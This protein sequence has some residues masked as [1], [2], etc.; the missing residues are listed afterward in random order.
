[1]RTVSSFVCPLFAS[2]G[3]WLLAAAS[4]QAQVLLTVTPASVAA[5][6]TGNVT[7]TV[8]GLTN[9]ESVQIAKYADLNKSGGIDSFEPVINAFRAQDGAATVIGGV[10]NINMPFDA[11]ATPETLVVKLNQGTQGFEQRMVGSYLITASSPTGRFA[12]QTVP[13]TITNSSAA[14]TLDGTVT[15]SGSPVPYAGVVIFPGN[16]ADSY[17]IFGVWAD[18]SGHYNV[19]LPAGTYTAM[20]LATSLV[21]DMQSLS[22]TT[23]SIGA[24]ATVNLTMATSTRVISGRLSDPNAPTVLFPAVSFALFSDDSHFV[25]ALADASGNF[26]VGV[27]PGTWH[28]SMDNL[29]VIS[30]LGYL[31]TDDSHTVDTTSGDVTGLVKEMAPATALIHGKITDANNNPIS[32]MEID[33]TDNDNHEAKVLTD[34]KG[35]FTLGVNAGVWNLDY[36]GDSPY[37][38][39]QTSGIFI[40]DGQ[41]VEANLTALPVSQTISGYLHTDSGTPLEGVGIW[42]NATLAGTTFNAYTETDENGFYSLGVAAGTWTVGVDSGSDSQSSLGSDYLIPASQ[43]VTLS[44]G[45]IIV[46]FTATKATC[47]IQGTVL[48]T[49][50]HAIA[51]VWVYAHATIGGVE[52]NCGAL[53][54][55][56]GGYQFGVIPGTWT[57]GLSC[58]SGDQTLNAMGYDCVMDESL[59]ILSGTA[60]INFSPS[61][62]D[63]LSVTTTSLPDGRVGNDYLQILSADGC[64]SPFTWSLAPSSAAL[65]E[66]LALTSSNFEYGWINGTPTVSGQFTVT[67]RVTDAN[68]ATA[69]QTFTFNIQPAA[70]TSPTISSPARLDASRIRFLV[71]GDAG[72]NYKVQYST[73]LSVDGWFTILTTNP[74]ATPFWFT[75]STTTRPQK[76]YRILIDN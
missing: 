2:V 1:M 25:F 15:C 66:G 10:T 11:N 45:D 75:D 40:R 4:L 50:N 6:Y 42:A 60:T 74:V 28:I 63:S 17:P 31:G 19:N 65:P 58:G 39:P 61:P 26:S 3:V 5:D 71:N 22:P 20:S 56:E 57:V 38:L 35:R 47:Q 12:T 36:N 37:L 7:I 62:C 33:A 55:S 21:A 46:N 30:Q 64:H 67:I 54:D 73:N 14:Q 59:P 24:K 8:A 48:G 44:G 70:I 72:L 27:L 49:D 23:L 52:Y 13:F 41:A 69:D 34:S 68:G 9:G 29:N 18:A 51:G 43:T 16:S 76:Y 32:G 53:T